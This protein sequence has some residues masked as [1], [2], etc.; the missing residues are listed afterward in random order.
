M[1]VRIAADSENR[2]KVLRLMDKVP[3]RERAARFRTVI[4]FY[5]GV[6]MQYIEGRCEGRIIS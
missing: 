2:K 4:C 3:N 6:D 1:L 5:D